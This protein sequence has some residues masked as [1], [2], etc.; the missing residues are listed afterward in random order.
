MFEVG[1]VIEFM[2]EEK[3]YYCGIIS[4]KINN[5]SCTLIL[6]INGDHYLYSPGLNTLKVMVERYEQIRKSNIPLIS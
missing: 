5:H 2:T 3:K 6:E 1:D 4:I